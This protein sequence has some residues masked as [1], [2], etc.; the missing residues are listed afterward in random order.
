M[1]TFNLNK[2]GHTSYEEIRETYAEKTR[3]S[4]NNAQR[5]R[6]KATFEV[7]NEQRAIL[8]FFPLEKQSFVCGV[9]L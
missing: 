5:C 3:C 2:A 4:S 8:A 9:G 6:L 1:L 7:P